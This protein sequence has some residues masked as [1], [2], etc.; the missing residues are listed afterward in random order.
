MLQWFLAFCDRV[1]F[2]NRSYHSCSNQSAIL[3]LCSSSGSPL[4]GRRY[5]TQRPREV[6]RAGIRGHS[7]A[8]SKI[9]P[10]EGA[11]MNLGQGKIAVRKGNDGKPHAVSASCTHKGCIV[12]WNNADRT[13][14]CPRQ[15][16]HDLTRLA[17]P[18]P[19]IPSGLS[20]GP[21]RT[22]VVNLSLRTNAAAIA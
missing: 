13:W 2:A 19:K 17:G 10:G 4:I 6:T 18:K 21:L 15:A 12:T 16:N 20:K 22:P 7:Y 8:V 1:S 14:D 3:Y 5:T 9:N 11:V